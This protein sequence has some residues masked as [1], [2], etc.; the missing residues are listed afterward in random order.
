MNPKIKI[1]VNAFPMVN[2]NTGIGRYLRCLYKALEEHC[3]DRVEIGYF[4]GSGVSSTMPS[5]P[6]NLTRW[7]TLVSLFWRLPTYPALWL[8]LMFHLNQERHFR[9]VVGDF[10]LYHEAAFFP[11]AA[12][13]H[14]KT[15]FTLTDLSLIRFPEHHPRERVLYS[16]LFFRRRCRRVKRF[17]S[18]SS[19]IQREMEDYL[20]I[21]RGNTTVTYLGYDPAVLY[22][23]PAMEIEDCL[24]R[25]D[26]PEKYFLFVGSG[27]PRKNMNVI[28]EA[29]DRTDLAVP[30]VVAG[31]SGWAEKT[32][33]AKVRF[34]GFVPDDDL[35]RL[36]SGALALIFPSCYEGFGLPILEAMACGCPVVTTREASMPEVAGDAAVYMGDPAD[37]DGLA[38]ILKELAENPLRR[39]EMVKKGLGQAGRFSWRNTAETTLRA[40]EK[41]LGEKEKPLLVKRQRTIT[42]SNHVPIC[43][44]PLKVMVGSQFLNVEIGGAEKYIHEVCSRLESQY[45]MTLSY[46]SADGL[47]VP[48]LSTVAYKFFSTGFH[49]A[50]RKEMRKTLRKIKPHV[51]Y[52][53]HTV[54]WVSDVLLRAA[55]DLNIPAVIMYHSDVTGP[56]W[57]KKMSGF[58]Y[59]RLFS[60]RSFSLCETFMVPSQSFVAQSPYLSGLNRE[61]VV[62]PPGVEP[63]MAEGRREV[64]N[65]YLL[66][67]GKPHLKS[68]GL[69]LLVRAWRSLRDQWPELELVVIGRTMKGFR[70]PEETGIR[71]RGYVASRKE[72]ADWYASAAVTVLSS[73]VPGESFGMVLAEALM[74]GCPVIGP[75]MGGVP[76]LIKDGLNGYLFVPGDAVD[77]T[78]AIDRALYGQE[79]LRRNISKER[80]MY[81]ARFNWDRTA[82]I[83]AEALRSAAMGGTRLKN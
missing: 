53:H 27:D 17:L 51:V 20:G 56:G 22:P 80:E 19:F 82:E 67:I 3:G 16:R 15:V 45:H 2:V 63:A 4:D 40:F 70:K 7:S 81:A 57:I 14:V 24:I 33:W 62:A 76:E 60:E 36:Y 78:R 9:K 68:K 74:A 30:L 23:R 44:T 28:P 11:F 54:P 58:F 18:I 12:P 49:P 47:G 66:F 65:P 42:A 1:L 69:H 13:V 32:S 35:A 55:A 21:S 48:G 41:A 61:V 6:E 77:L 25:Y 71:Y 31:W 46:L 26:L 72:L 79:A 75:R 83:V 43:P 29:L 52:V 64:G 10:D 50:W 34:L 59:H 73:T 5:G 39:R 8:R 37:A 38:G